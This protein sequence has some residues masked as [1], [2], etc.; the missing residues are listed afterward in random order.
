MIKL[1]QRTLQT[2]ACQQYNRASSR[3]I[4]N[5]LKKAQNEPEKDEMKPIDK[6]EDQTELVGEDQASKTVGPINP[7]ESQ[8][9]RKLYEPEEEEGLERFDNALSKTMYEFDI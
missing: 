4:F 2:K 5:F 9:L 1:A 3:S 7:E 8:L 6:N